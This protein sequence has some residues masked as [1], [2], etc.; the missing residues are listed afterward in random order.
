MKG[1]RGREGRERALLAEGRMV[2]NTR[3][4]RKLTI[5]NRIREPL[6]VKQDKEGNT[7]KDWITGE[8]R[9]QGQRKC[10]TEAVSGPC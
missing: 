4:H 5:V 7:D 1:G 6:G 10:A 9:G 8:I 2:K 3:G